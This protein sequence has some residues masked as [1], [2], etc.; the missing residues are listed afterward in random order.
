MY[1]VSLVLECQACPAPGQVCD[2]DTGECVCPI[3]TIGEMCE[4][5]TANAWDYHPLKGCRLCECASEG[6]ASTDCNL[7]TGQCHCRDEY[8]MLGIVDVKCF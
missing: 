6:S 2:S 3:N 8:G 5:C 7:R 4:N 1:R